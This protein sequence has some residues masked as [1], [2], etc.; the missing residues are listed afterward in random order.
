ML[1]TILLPLVLTLSKAVVANSDTNATEELGQGPYHHNFGL[2]TPFVSSC[3]NKTVDVKFRWSIRD[4]QY[5]TT[6]T[7]MSPTEE[8]QLKPSVEST[9]FSF[10]ITNPAIGGLARCNT[11]VN[12]PIPTS[13]HIFHCDKWLTINNGTHGLFGPRGPRLALQFV[14]RKLTLNDGW[15]CDESRKVSGGSIQYSG[16]GLAE[17]EFFQCIGASSITGN[18]EPGQIYS[19]RTIGCRAEEINV[20]PYYLL[21]VYSGD[22][23]FQVIG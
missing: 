22:P 9:Y 11:T 2:N 21:G 6:S 13:P 3:S 14:D 4:F 8:S 7:F 10:N 5:T 17:L 15:R 20:K 1:V 16:R 23:F 18:W 12:G 19:Q